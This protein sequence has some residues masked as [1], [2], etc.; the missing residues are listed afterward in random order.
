MARLGI[1]VVTN[2]T[3]SRALTARALG[4]PDHRQ[5]ARWF[6]SR[7]SDGVDPVVVAR[8]SA[9]VQQVIWRGD[10]ANLQRLPVL[11]QHE[12]EPGPYL[13]AA[14]A[15]TFDPDTGVDNP[16]R[17]SAA[18]CGGPR[19]MTW[20]PY[21][22]THNARNLRKFWSK[23]EP[24]RS[25]SGSGTIRPCCSARRRSCAIRRNHWR[26]QAACSG[27]PCAWCPR[28]CNERIMVP[29]DAEIVIEGFAPPND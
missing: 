10:R 13:T 16:R 7:T 4:I 11:T 19:R 29:A 2:L 3:A 18:G 22:T 5:T 25:R 28:C 26:T 1:P 23:G 24:V 17:S 9:P 14:H 8:E 21:P 6:A 12:L 27:N 20:L 15:T